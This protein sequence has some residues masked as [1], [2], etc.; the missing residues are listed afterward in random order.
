VRTILKIEGIELRTD[1]LGREYW[2]TYAILD[3]GSEVVGYGKVFEVGDKVMS[4]Y[5][6]E[7]HKM[8]K[9]LTK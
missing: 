6:K 2:R 5:H 7:V 3:D 4:Y 1:K 9:L 8:S